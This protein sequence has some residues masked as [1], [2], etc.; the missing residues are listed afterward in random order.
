MTYY[1]KGPGLENADVCDFLTLALV[2][3]FADPYAVA[4]L[5]EQRPSGELPPPHQ[6]LPLSRVLILPLDITTPH[7][8]SFPLYAQRIDTGFRPDR[9][10]IAA[11]K[12]PITHFS[13]AFLQRTREVMLEFGNDAMELHDVV[14]VWAAAK[15]PPVKDDAEEVDLGL[16]E[17]WGA[18]RRKFAMERYVLAF[19]AIGTLR[20][21]IHTLTWCKRQDGRAGA[22]DVH[23]R[24]KI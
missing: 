2:N 5:L 11:G 24:Q 7:E 14:A 10:S 4:E 15:N 22:W 20:E 23:R 18:T 19:A 21:L 16:M 12:S 1:S 17:G 3:F 13:S 6:G 8:L 9:P